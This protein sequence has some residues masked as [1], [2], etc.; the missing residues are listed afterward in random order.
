MIVFATAVNF[1]LGYL[2]ALQ[3]GRSEQGTNDASS[4]WWAPDNSVSFSHPVLF[5]CRPRDWD[6]LHYCDSKPLVLC[7]R[8]TSR[9]GKAS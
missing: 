5:W 8:K 1:K 6:W 4:C 7:K 9:I 3:L 2:I